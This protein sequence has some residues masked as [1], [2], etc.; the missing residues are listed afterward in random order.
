MSPPQQRE[1]AITGV[2]AIR[3]ARLRVVRPL[4]AGSAGELAA[5]ER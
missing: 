3:R 1:R 5:T 4:K 2:I